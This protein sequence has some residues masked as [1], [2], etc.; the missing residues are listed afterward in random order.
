MLA[1]YDAVSPSEKQIVGQVTPILVTF[2]DQ[3]NLPGAPPPLH[4]MFSR[5][6]FKDRLEYF[7]IDELVDSVFSGK[8]RNELSLVLSHA[9]NEIVGNADIERPVESTGENIDKI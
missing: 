5:P 8:A 3:P 1:K 6:R 7:K 4:R 2:L 9:S